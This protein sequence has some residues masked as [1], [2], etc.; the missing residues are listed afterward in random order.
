MLNAEAPISIPSNLVAKRLIAERAFRDGCTASEVVRQAIDHSLRAGS[1]VLNGLD[2]PHVSARL[3]AGQQQH[4][5]R[6]AQ[7]AGVSHSQ[8][9]EAMLCEFLFGETPALEATNEPDLFD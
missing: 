3:T 6:Y 2:K 9:L 8:A 7:Q 4:L 1:I 5:K